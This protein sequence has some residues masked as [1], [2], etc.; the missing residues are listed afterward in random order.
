MKKWKLGILAATVVG[1][2]AFA[3]PLRADAAGKTGWVQ[4]ETD[5][6]IWYYYVEG[7]AQTGWQLING[8]SYY[9]DRNGVMQTGWVNDGGKWFYLNDKGQLHTGWLEEKGKWYYLAKEEMGSTPYV[10]ECVRGQMVK[11]KF[12]INGKGYFFD[13]KTGAMKTSS[14]CV[15]DTLSEPIWY[16]ADA[17]GILHTG[18]LSLNGKWYYFRPDG[19]RMS[20]GELKIGNKWYY[21][22]YET[23]AMKTG[24]IDVSYYWV[25][26]DSSGALVT[27][28]K[29]IGGKSYYFDP[30]FAE[31]LDREYYKNYGILATEQYI[32]GYW[33][34]KDG[35]W[36][37]KPRASWHKSG[38][39]W[40]Y[41]DNAGWYAK[42]KGIV[43]DGKMYVFDRN[44][45]L[46]QDVPV[47]D[48]E[49]SKDSLAD[50]LFSVR[51]GEAYEN[52]VLTLNYG[53]LDRACLLIVKTNGK[54]CFCEKGGTGY[55]G[56]RPK[57]TQADT[58]D[59]VLEQ[60]KDY[61][62]EGN[63]YCCAWNVQKD[64]TIY[65]YSVDR[66]LMKTLTYDE[67]IKKTYV[68]T[69]GNEPWR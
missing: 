43:I 67:F 31:A 63:E 36:T 17:T 56:P 46:I 44:G 13:K 62:D 25:Y 10:D 22:D 60:T 8:K 69:E 38:K 18:W 61:I 57:Y 3:N 58:I 64:S 65:I 51:L 35:S 47:A 42:G 19:G 7:E 30:V 29:N 33:L 45:Y 39:R 26:A 59:E 68:Y 4:D 32:Q 20:T 11:G 14:W 41:G 9:F 52:A 48:K 24:W 15:I 6:N 21:F 16:Y 37:Y 40:W 34:N 55:H 54:Y 2:L 1:A 27:G 12:E 50:S 23:G 53:T 5:T 28:W 66:T 49:S